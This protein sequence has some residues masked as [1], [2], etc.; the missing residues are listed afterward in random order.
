MEAIIIIGVITAGIIALLGLIRVSEDKVDNNALLDKENI[1]E[2]SY[3]YNKRLRI[4]YQISLLYISTEEFI[5]KEANEWFI[6]GEDDNKK[7]VLFE[8][9]LIKSC[10]DVET[11]ENII[12]EKPS[13]EADL[14]VLMEIKTHKDFKKLQDR[15]HN[16]E[17]HLDINPDNED[18]QNKLYVL[19]KMSYI[20]LLKPYKCYFRDLPSGLNVPLTLLENIGK[21]INADDML[22]IYEA[23]KHCY[24]DHKFLIEYFST[25]FEVLNMEEYLELENPQELAQSYLTQEILQLKQLRTIF[26][27]ISIDEDKKRLKFNN[28]VKQSEFLTQEL[29]DYDGADYYDKYLDL[30]ESGN[31]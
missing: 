23:I 22:R 24:P 3:L 8:P 28:F 30:N 27:D 18:A 5:F 29:E 20:A 1:K 6:T 12:F 17:M 4:T 13:T 31:Q 9:R 25:Y 26:E 19:D 21:I 15:I 14:R 16:L 2:P 7:E 11:N 10:I